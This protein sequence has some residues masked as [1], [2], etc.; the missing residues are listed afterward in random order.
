MIKATK[1]FIPLSYVIQEC[2]VSPILKWWI[3]VLS[4]IHLYLGC[5]CLHQNLGRRTRELEA[6]K[7]VSSRNRLYKDRYQL[8]PW[9]FHDWYL[10]VLPTSID[11]IQACFPTGT[12]GSPARKIVFDFN[13]MQRCFHLGAMEMNLIRTWC[14]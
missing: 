12:F 7:I 1:I 6:F 10:R 3:V 14:L 11:L 2:L 4:I 5:N 8:I 9:R 13:D